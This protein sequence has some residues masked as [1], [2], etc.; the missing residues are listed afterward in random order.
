MRSRFD[1]VGT[2]LAGSLGST[3]S[4]G[5]SSATLSLLQDAEGNHCS[6]F[7]ALLLGLVQNGAQLMTMGRQDPQGSSGRSPES[8]ALS[9]L[10]RATAFDPLAWGNDLKSRTPEND[11][12]NREHVAFAHRAAACIYLS[13]VAL[14]VSPTVALKHDLEALVTEVVYHLSFVQPGD[15]LLPASTWPAFVAGAET[16]CAEKMA[17]V[18]R[19]LHELWNAEPWGLFRGA[20]EVLEG[21]WE[22]RARVV[23]S[24]EIGSTPSSS[25]WTPT[26]W[27][28]D[29]R[30]QGVDWLII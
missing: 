27:L 7:P 28:D 22:K 12:P 13:R 18:T 2:T 23:T 16:C 17:W 5:F 29:L 10:K 30:S 20:L 24:S 15:A 21:I 4:S 25:E 1:I 8:L 9:L 11:H 26:N 3:T 19:R 14:S 6:S